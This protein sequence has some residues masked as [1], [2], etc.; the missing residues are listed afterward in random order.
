MTAESK[1]AALYS[2]VSTQEQV[3]RGESIPFQKEC[4]EK[5]AREM[6]YSLFRHYCDEAKSGGSA[7]R[8]GFLRMLSDIE[9][10]SIGAAIFYDFSRSSRDLTDLLLLR[11]TLEDRNIVIATCSEKIDL[12]TDEG[13]FM[14]KVQ[15]IVNERYRKDTI[16][17]VKAKMWDKAS[18]GEYCGGI[19]AFG[20]KAVKKH[21]VQD[22]RES[23]IVREIYNRF[24]GYPYY[25]GIT[26]WLN[27]M[28]YRTREG[29]EF[30]QSTVKRILIS[31]SYKGYLTYGKRSEGS[32]V[33]LPK[34]KWTIRKGDFEPIISEEQWNRVQKIIA[35]RKFVRPQKKHG[36]RFALSCLMRCEC[37]GTLNGYTMVKKPS[38][39]MYCYYKCHNSTSKGI[40]VCSGNTLRKEEIERLII[41]KIRTDVKLHFEEQEA[42][43][44]ADKERTI[45]LE[46]QLKRIEKNISDLDAKKVRCLDLYLDEKYAK[47]ELDERVCKIKKD[48]EELESVREKIRYEINPK[49]KEKR[50]DIYERIKALNGDIFSLSD[51]AK[52]DIIK[53]VVKSVSVSRNKDVGVEL[54]DL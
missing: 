25:R 11:R 28:G 9:S 29:K 32:K 38:G 52:G 37:G 3:D 18:K 34:E 20:Y 53:Q 26:V 4:L 31:E 27:K 47:E 42:K 45:S 24:E 10:D 43:S 41:D 6:G 40:T 39:K 36:V 50:Q 44:V 54:Y 19:T 21:L 23:H 1:V 49:E 8:L 15:G 46:E 5:K 16:K 30:A 12:N 7:K 48:R 14:F 33:Y 22:E 51:N 2:R 13:D 35:E 17:R